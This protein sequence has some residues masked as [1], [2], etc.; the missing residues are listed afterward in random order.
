MPSASRHTGGQGFLVQV[1]E[2][3]DEWA[4]EGRWGRGGGQRGC[5]AQSEW[6]RAGNSLAAQRLG[7][8]TA[9]A[10]ERVQALLGELR[11]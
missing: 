1:E 10:G 11:T 8:C 4:A 5:G 6:H 2:R 7:L 9:T 3:D